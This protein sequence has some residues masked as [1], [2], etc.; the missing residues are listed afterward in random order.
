[1]GQ[2]LHPAISPKRQDEP[3]PDH[4]WQLVLWDWDKTECLVEADQLQSVEEHVQ[5]LMPAGVDQCLHHDPGKASPME[6]FEGE[7]AIDFVPVRMK[8][9]T[10]RYSGKCPVDKGAEY[11]VF[12]GG[13]GSCWW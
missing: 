9:G 12:V 13:L 10:W 4:P 1:M 2:T 6:L 3:L 5:H 11:A 7:D 8:P